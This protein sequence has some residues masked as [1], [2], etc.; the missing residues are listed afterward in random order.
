MSV[1][2]HSI[3]AELIAGV[4]SG[5]DMA[6]ERGF[7]GLFPA[8]VAEA[9]FDLH[10]KASATRVVERAFLQVMSGEPPTDAGAFDQALIQAIHQSVVREQSRLAALRRFEHNEGVAHDEH[11]AAGADA[12]HAWTHIKEARA[13]AAAGHAPVDPREG[14]HAAA[15]HMSA[16]IERDSR[17]K[18][19]VPL[20]G[21]LILVGAGALAVARMDFRPSEK[22]VMAQLN[23]PNAKTIGA[24]PGQVGNI[25]LSDGTVLKIAAGSQLRLN[26]DFNQKLRAILVKGTA[27]FTIAPDKKPLELRAGDVAL[28]ATEGQVDVRADDDRPTLLRI[29]SG[30]PRIV[31][32]DSSWTAAAGQAL[33]FDKGVVRAADPAELDESFAWMQGQFYVKG[34]VRDVVDGIRRW[35]D[36]D[37]GIGDN[38]IASWPATASGSLES[39]AMTLTSL[40]KSA[41]VKM[42]WQNRQM[43]LFRK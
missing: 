4:Q 15:A 33:V 43:L 6:I 23:S 16:A 27:S 34:T 36:M 8:L 19:L 31:I 39:L 29:V 26:N 18:V 21:G 5:D 12:A 40:E 11:H 9:D 2:S 24:R 25:S 41:K 37:V 1:T 14:Q 10:D 28:S 17:R 38:S 22:F 20:V 30:S 42:V 35:Y 32:G 3:P 7:H 13:R